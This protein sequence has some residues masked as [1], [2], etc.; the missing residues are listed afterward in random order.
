M[1]CL[2][3]VTIVNNKQIFILNFYQLYF[4][5]TGFQK[6]YAVQDISLFKYFKWPPIGNGSNDFSHNRARPTFWFIKP[7]C[8]NLLKPIQGFGHHHGHTK[9]VKKLFLVI[10][11]QEDIAHFC[12]SFNY[13][14]YCKYYCYFTLLMEMN[15][16]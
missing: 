13:C 2:N 5:A 12:R 7:F 8:N 6:Q 1:I 10:T 15:F 4:G 16:V 14:S 3:C 11:K 9:T